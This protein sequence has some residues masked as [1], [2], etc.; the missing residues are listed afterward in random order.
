M[1]KLVLFD[2]DGTIL[3]S[4]GAGTRSI[5]SALS[6][7]FERDVEAGDGY[8]M[9]GK[10]DAQIVV[11]LMERSGVSREETLERLRDVWDRY[12]EGMRKEIGARAPD[13]FPG[14]RQLVNRLSEATEALL[15]LLTGNIEEV[16][17][18]KLGRVEL[19]GPFWAGAFGDQ[20]LNRSE[21]PGVAIQ[22]AASVSG[23]T[24]EGKD[25]VIVGDTPN[26][27]LCGRHLNVKTVA[28]ATGE[29]S[30]EELAEYEPDYLF[31]DLIDTVRVGGAIL[32]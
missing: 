5:M 24:F 18:I 23:H 12:A 7:V 28:V 13:V 31:D 15:G 6:A 32:E 1:K 19:D 29:F 21:L 17:W 11:E 25:V 30:R 8:S 14:V 20:A 4:F 9:S 16:A 26:D 2:I 10:T 27:V 22:N 3:S